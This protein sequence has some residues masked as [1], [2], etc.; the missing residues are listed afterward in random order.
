MNLVKVEN[1]E[2][3]DL[4]SDLILN[5]YEDEFN[6]QYFDTFAFGGDVFLCNSYELVVTESWVIDTALYANLSLQN[7]QG[8][9]IVYTTAYKVKTGVFPDD[10]TY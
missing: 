10:E 2:I 6:E 3:V 8:E 5:I 1:N 7:E 4:S 9:E